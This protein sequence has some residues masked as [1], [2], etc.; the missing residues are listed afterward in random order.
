MRITTG[1]TQSQ[2]Q[3]NINRNIRYLDKLYNQLSTGKKI[4]VP[5]DDPII[6][7]RALKFRTNVSETE[8]YM[9]N[10][11]NAM[12][13][14]GVTEQAFKNI[15]NSL[16]SLRELCTEGASDQFTYSDR[17]SMTA[18]MKEIINQMGV[19]L[20]QT[21]GGRYVF[22]GYRTDK[23]ATIT[24][25]NRDAKYKI[26]QQLSPNNIEKGM[27]YS[28]D[29]TT[30]EVE[31]HDVEKMVIPYTDV[32]NI[33]LKIN[34]ATQ[35]VTTKSKDDADAYT[36]ADDG[37]NYI[38]ET[39][40][41][42]I[43]KEVAAKMRENKDDITI[44]YDVEGLKKG[45]LNPEIYF[46]CKDLT[47]TEPTYYFTDGTVMNPFVA[48]E[49]TR[50]DQYPFS[51]KMEY[52]F[53]ANTRLQVNCMAKDSLPASI[54]AELNDLVNLIDSVETT[55]P[56]VLR[57][58]YEGQDGYETE[59]EVNEAV[60]KHIE[61]EEQQYRGVMQKAF[62][63]MIGNIDEENKSISKEYTT[64]GSRMNRLEMVEKRLKDDRV[65]Y[66]TLMSD[67][68]NIDIMQVA[69]DKTAAQYVYNASL[70]AGMGIIQTSLVDFLN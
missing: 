18:Q 7:S 68:E 29:A 31:V 47:K 33:D 70:K 41:L 55:D 17:Q 14:S 48:G 4:Q 3:L 53:G 69:M 20:N 21:Y 9:R 35:A 45:D 43:G 61:K 25:D 36:V 49:Y 10:V 5:S 30:Y 52:E 50:T 39:G 34:G 8:Q 22:S 38:K 40:E 1:M 65:T 56:N 16:D 66:T 62:S 28:K 59:E 58:Y 11:S 24:E 15:N 6:A 27:A 32:K 37:V 46:N 44:Q 23:P 67:N 19:E 57:A 63:N 12:S 54:M 60:Q 26:H 2:M 13:W 51:Q 42:I 64:L